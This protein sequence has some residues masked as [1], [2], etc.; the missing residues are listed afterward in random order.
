MG[1]KGS[2]YIY[3][4]PGVKEFQR[5]YLNRVTELTGLNTDLGNLHAYQYC[6][7]FYALGEF[8]DE[9]KRHYIEGVVKNCK[10]GLIIWNP[11]S[12]ASE[13]IG[14]ECKVEDEFPLTSPNNKML[15]W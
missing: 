10:H 13:E 5:K 4:L 11:H 9:L 1:Y 2:Y 8:D 14:F 7:S 3:D 6:V 15:T 12:G